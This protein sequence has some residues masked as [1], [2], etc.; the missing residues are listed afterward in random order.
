MDDSR[1]KATASFASEATLGHKGSGLVSPSPLSQKP[2]LPPSYNDSTTLAAQSPAPTTDNN[3]NDDQTKGAKAK[4][5]AKK[6]FK[7]YWFLLGLAI[8]ISVARAAPDVARK[9]GYIHAEW[10]IKWGAVIIIFLISGLSL[11]TK[12]LTQTL[13]RVRLHLLVQIINLI[14][15]PFFVFGL[16]LLLFKL[17][18]PMNSLVLMGV[19]IAASTPTTVSSNVV[20]TKNAKGNE[21]TALMNAALGNVLGIF[22]S[23]ALV[24][25]FQEPLIE[26]TPENETAQAGGSVDF[27]SVLKQ[28]GLTVLVPLVVGQIIQLIFTEQVARIKVKWRLSDVSSVCLLLMVWS[29]FCDAFYAGSFNSVSATDIV[30]VVI[31]NFGFYILFSLLAMFLS[32]IPFPSSLKEPRWVKRMRFS[33]EDTVAVMFCG[34]TKTVAMGVPLINVLYESG[35]PGTVGVLSTPLLLYHVEQ[36][37]LGNIEVDILKRW[38]QKGNERDAAKAKEMPPARDEEDHADDMPPR[39]PSPVETLSN[40]P[41]TLS[42]DHGGKHH[43]T[44]DEKTQQTYDEKQQQQH[45]DAIEY[46]HQG[47]ATKANGGHH[48]ETILLDDEIDPSRPTSATMIEDRSAI[49]ESRQTMRQSSD[50]TSQQHG[51]HTN[52]TLFTSEFSLEA[53]HLSN[54]SH[55]STSQHTS[56]RHPQ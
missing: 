22:I 36:L 29:V 44:L 20:M 49:N 50:I 2:S 21:A 45:D 28:L 17:H 52:S 13:L 32:Y 6:L 10:S 54:D 8:V 16:V 53:S 12:I 9:G 14:I 31:M 40:K 47:A 34:A 51:N 33:R 15:I 25:T 24:D 39:S 3:T 11:R 37:I 19:V 38:V 26:A 46:M 35:D 27:V 1:L 55:Y 41:Y 7:K 5:L 48:M 4:A 30:A 42:A 56:S 18:T 23:P 43:S